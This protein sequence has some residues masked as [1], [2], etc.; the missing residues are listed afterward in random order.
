MFAS[1]GANIK[2]DRDGGSV[3]LAQFFATGIAA[4][5]LASNSQVANA[6]TV[7]P[8]AVGVAMAEAS[9]TQSPEILQ[10]IAEGAVQAEKNKTNGARL[11]ACATIKAPAK[12][13]TI[14]PAAP[15]NAALASIYPAFQKALDD[16]KSEADFTRMIAF[17]RPDFGA[18]IAATITSCGGTPA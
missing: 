8:T 13:S 4:Q 6:L 12:L 7:Q 18:E 3:G 5:R 10:A 1:F 9:A 11:A 2:G 17:Y 16:A 14:A 15:S